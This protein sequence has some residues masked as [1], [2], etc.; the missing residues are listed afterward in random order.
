MAKI[1]TV[2]KFIKAEMFV[3]SA[4]VSLFLSG[5]PVLLEPLKPDDLAYKLIKPWLNWPSLFSDALLI[6]SISAEVLVY[7]LVSQEATEQE[8]SKGML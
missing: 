5:V 4:S 6:H 7:A 2:S 3:F 1:T 8:K